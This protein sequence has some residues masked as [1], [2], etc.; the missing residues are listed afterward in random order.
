[1]SHS[2]IFA[3]YNDSQNTI[4]V[5]TYFGDVNY[6]DSRTDIYQYYEASTIRK[7]YLS[8]PFVGKMTEDSQGKI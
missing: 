8:F 7:D 1:M 4:W 2:S 3:L 5:G 6:F